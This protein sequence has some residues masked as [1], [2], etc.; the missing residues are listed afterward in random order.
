[1]NLCKWQTNSADLRA[2]WTES[3]MEHL[4]T[5]ESSG[6]VLKVLGLVWRAE[7]DDF[8]FDLKGLLDTLKGKENTKRSDSVLQTSTRIFD[9]GGF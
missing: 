2:Q 4:N 3:K 5:T 6:N 9:P 1:M 8:V 7:T